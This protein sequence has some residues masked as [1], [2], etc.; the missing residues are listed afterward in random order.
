MG[1]N[2]KKNVV[3]VYSGEV[4][5]GRNRRYVIVEIHGSRL[6][7]ARNRLAALTTT[8]GGRTLGVPVLLRAF[9]ETHGANDPATCG[10]FRASG[11]TLRAFIYLFFFSPSPGDGVR[12]STAIH[13]A[14]ADGLMVL[15]LDFF[16]RTRKTH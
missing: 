6:V 2:V 9:D 5:A 16:G 1:F 13:Y 8:R 4:V 15:A 14:S 3:V 10:R 12:L 11:F 7:C